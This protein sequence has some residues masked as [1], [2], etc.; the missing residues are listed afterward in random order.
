MGDY[1]AK[2][3]YDRAYDGVARYFSP[4]VG[5]QHRANVVAR[6]R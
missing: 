5:D 6:V 1:S 3:S 2:G 4:I